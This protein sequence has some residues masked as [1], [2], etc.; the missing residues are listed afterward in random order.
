[1][2]IRS[3]KVGACRGLLLNN[4]ARSYLCRHAS[5]VLTIFTSS[6]DVLE[7]IWWSPCLAWSEQYHS[8]GRRPSRS[9]ATTSG[10]KRRL[11]A[12]HS[13]VFRLEHVCG[14]DAASVVRQ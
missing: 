7:S 8:V 3:F 2:H 12:E 5:F 14:S 10:Q 1:M 9:S 11:I 6:M 13:C 4:P